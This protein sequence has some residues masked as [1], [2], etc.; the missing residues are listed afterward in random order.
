MTKFHK[1]LISISSVLFCLLGIIEKDIFIKRENVYWEG[2]NG[3][4]WNNFR[5]YPNFL[6]EFD[7]AITS[8]FTYEIVGDNMDTVL[9]RTV[10]YPHHS[11]VKENTKDYK[12][13]LRHEQYHFNISEAIARKFRKSLTNLPQSSFDER[14]IQRIYNQHIGQLE[15]YQN[16]YDFDTDHS[17]IFERQK[18]WEYIVDSLLNEY[19]YYV[20]PIVTRIKKNKNYTYYRQIDIDGKGKIYGRFPVDSTIALKT[21]HYKFYY[22]NNVPVKIEYWDRNKPATDT[23]FGAHMTKISRNNNIT[24]TSFHN[25][26]NEKTTTSKGVHLIKDEYH[27]KELITSYYDIDGNPCE[28]NLGIHKKVWELDYKKRRYVGTLYNL[29]NQ[30]I[31]DKE[32]Y[33]IIKYNY[34]K[35]D[36]ISEILNYDYNN[37]LLNLYNGVAKFS[38]LYDEQNN[39]TLVQSFDSDLNLT[40]HEGRTAIANLHYDINGNV[41]RESY[42]DKKGKPI[43][44]DNK[45]ISYYTYDEYSNL[46]EEKYYGLN[47]NLIISEDKTGKTFSKYDSL[48]RITE[49]SNYDA[50]GYLLN[51]AH[52]S[53]RVKQFFDES[54]II[55][56]VELFHKDSLDSLS[57]LKTIKYEFDS[58][59]DL[60]SETYLDKELNLLPD[61]NGVCIIRYE[62]DKKGNLLSVKNYNS[63]YYLTPVTYKV[64]TFQYKYDS[65]GNKI[66][67]AYFDPMNMPAEDTTGIAKDV[68]EY[69]DNNKMIER[70]YYDSK[71]QLIENVNGVKIIKWTYDDKNNETSEAY[72]DENGQR[73]GD[74][75]GVSYL[76][77]E[78]DS[79]NNKT[80]TKIYNINNELVDKEYS[81]I[82]QILNEYDENNRVKVITY[83]D[84]NDNLIDVPEGFAIVMHSYNSYGDITKT[85]Y[86]SKYKQP[87]VTTYGY[88]SINWLYDNNRNTIAEIYRDENGEFIE[89]K[90]GYALKN[91][92]H[93]RNGDVIDSY[94][95]TAQET[96]L[97][98]IYYGDFATT[99]NINDY[100]YGIS[101]YANNVTRVQT[102]YYDNGQKESEGYYINGKFEGTYTSWYISGEVESTIE[103]RDGKRNGVMIEYYKNGQKKRELYY[104]NNTYI[105]ITEITWHENG[106]IRSQYVNEEYVSWDEEGNKIKSEIKSA[107]L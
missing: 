40:P 43:L 3:L 44:D 62:R 100:S 10:M 48:G 83:K 70:R 19:S 60:L 106:K 61:S 7:A 21:D 15:F 33:C 53:C 101:S 47:K 42:E 23:Y 26:K 6:S 90:E 16:K 88:A 41:I 91:W 93:N 79:N 98:N 12:E 74:K 2:S 107:R 73:A 17:I 105:K 38:Y 5:G 39:I 84:K 30:K 86:F 80:L 94:A 77:Y 99:V 85:E 64:S 54:N 68:Y 24:E 59:Y 63:K 104:E 78:Y 36:N 71:N 18:D 75:D 28:N 102:T 29:N 67:A 50:Y 20:S 13:A 9:V 57:F 22:K 72:Y 76:T 58:N 97:S 95:Y 27:E 37:K 66:E 45:A 46:V 82:A 31:T 11:W 81:G 25:Q 1:Y 65:R 69:N 35:N 32:G 51:N 4:H 103:F 55:S 56:H 52:G 8:H 96:S 92:L 87:V 14:T 89:D 49:Y 34:D